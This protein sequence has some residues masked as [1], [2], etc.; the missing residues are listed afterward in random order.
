MHVLPG[1][2]TPVSVTELLVGCG[3]FV[4]GIILGWLLQRAIVGRLRRHA[5]I[6]TWG[7]DD[8]V[9]NAIRDVVVIWFGVAGAFA[10]KAAL[11]LQRTLDEGISTT[12]SAVLVISATLVL[13]RMVGDIV[14][15]YSMRSVRRMR[16][17]SI[18]VNFAR[19]LI[20]LMGALVLLQTLGVSIAPLLTALGVGGLAVAL[21]LQDTLS[22]FFA[23][24][25]IIA[26]KNIKPGD[27]VRLESG[28]EGYVVDIDWRHTSVRQLRDSVLVIPNSKLATSVITNYHY[29]Q[30]ELALLVHVGVAY[31]SDLAHV[32]RVTVE[33]ARDVQRSVEGAVATFE[34]FI[35]YHTFGDS[36]IEFTVIMRVQEFTDQF[37]VRHEFVKRLHE[38]YALEGVVIPFPIRTLDLPE[39]VRIV[40]D[41][42]RTSRPSAARKRK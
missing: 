32:E 40:E 4:G 36:Q 24:L 29:P 26:T 34:P 28:E 15:L 37:L 21:A 42:A 39:S 23:G 17:S 6:T 31:S 35:R 18:F 11:P 5:T 10:G 13:A 3:L 9:V 2:T 7:G 20:F 27:F 19:V 8:I 25:Q 14:K 22:N 12:L 1:F 16:S 33:V 41:V 30:K 38:R